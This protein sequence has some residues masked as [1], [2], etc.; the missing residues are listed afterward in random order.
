MA[1]KT[2]L[3]QVNYISDNPEQD[4]SRF[5]D[6]MKHILTAPK[7]RPSDKSPTAPMEVEHDSNRTDDSSQ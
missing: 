7:Q 5:Q 1:E 6:A 3:P 4:W 2:A